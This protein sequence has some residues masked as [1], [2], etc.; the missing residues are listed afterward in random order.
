MLLSGGAWQNKTCAQGKARSHSEKR[1]RDPKSLL[2]RSWR[3][4]NMVCIKCF[5]K[6]VCD[7]TSQ[8]FNM[9]AAV[10]RRVSQTSSSSVQQ[11]HCIRRSQCCQPGGT[12]VDET[13]TTVYWPTASGTEGPDKPVFR[14]LY[15]GANASELRDPARGEKPGILS[16]RRD[17]TSRNWSSGP[18]VSPR[19]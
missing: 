2:A 8:E 19:E 5:G 16:E 10:C 4:P 9:M 3:A 7:T 15:T 18:R 17:A 13:I 12:L 6:P 11:Q 14:N 1:P